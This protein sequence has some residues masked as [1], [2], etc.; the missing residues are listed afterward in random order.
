MWKKIDWLKDNV[1]QQM[2]QPKL[3]IVQMR[4]YNVFKKEK[5]EAE[6]ND[7]VRENKS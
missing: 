7:I 3:G 5:V 2:Q 1:Q 6:N 4:R